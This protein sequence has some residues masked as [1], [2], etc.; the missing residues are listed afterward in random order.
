MNGVDVVLQAVAMYKSK[1]PKSSDEENWWRICLCCLLMPLENKERFVKAERVELMIII[2]KQKKLAYA[3]AIR[4]IDFAMTNYPPACE[5]FF[6]V[7]GL[8]TTFA[9]A[10]CKESVSTFATLIN[11]VEPSRIHLLY[12]VMLL[13]SYI[14]VALVLKGFIYCTLFSISKK[15]KKERYHEEF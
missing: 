12:C 5:R 3:F 8:K 9:K 4:A 1:D 7:L 6:D 11:F 15:N 10:L 2:M 13:L 14:W